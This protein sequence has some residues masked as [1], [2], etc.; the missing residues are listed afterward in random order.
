MTAEATRDTEAA[1]PTQPP[2]AAPA[3]LAGI[4]SQA[5]D[6]LA[7]LERGDVRPGTV[8]A[9]QRAA[10]NAALTGVLARQAGTVAPPGATAAPTNVAPDWTTQANAQA[11]AQATRTR[12]ITQLLPYMVTHSDQVVRNTAEL[13]MGASPLLT[14]DAITKRSDSAVQVAK[15]GLPAWV[16]ARAHDAFFTGVAMNNVVFHEPN[17]IGTL[18]GTTMYVRGHDSGGN[19]LSMDE[20]AGVVTHEVS[21]WLVKQYGELPLTDVNAS[22]FDRYADEFRAYWIQYKSMAGSKTGADRAKAIRE[23]LVGTAGDPNSGYSNFHSA[24]FAAG[25]GPNPFKQQV[26]ALSGPLGYNLTNSIRLHGLWQQLTGRSTAAPGAA[27]TDDLILFIDALPVGERAEAARSTLIQ[28][29]TAKIGG[30]DGDRIKA[31]LNAPTVPEYTDKI[32][33]GHSAAIAAMLKAIVSGSGDEMKKAYASLSLADK[34]NLQWNAAFL[35]YVDFHLPDTAARA[36]L[37]AM[38]SNFSVAQY[39]AMAAFISSLKSAR[40]EQ[41]LFGL[42]GVPQYVLDAMGKLT[43]RSRWSFF[44]WSRKTA[45]KEYVDVLPA[46]VAGEIRE[47][48]RD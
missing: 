43:D 17:M 40:A 6:A 13:F 45:V 48:L 7:R 27:R 24:Y 22:S 9:L 26:D 18:T 4:T 42:T 15:P 46:D 30:A 23:H 37:Y 29:L 25:P 3:P 36:C 39:D 1:T 19:L 8:L 5:A 16:T 33:P 12:L 11:T 31:A 47:R 28:G 35:A 14:M 44:S 32:N 2:V 34:Q 41:A 10:G 20:M 38:T 21:H